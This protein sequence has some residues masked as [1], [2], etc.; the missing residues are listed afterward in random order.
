MYTIKQAA[1]LTGVAEATLR[2]WERR[3]DVVRPIRNEA[4]HRIYDKGAIAAI[5]ALRKLI[6][7][8]WAPAQAARAIRDGEIEPTFAAGSDLLAPPAPDDPP[9]V[10]TESFRDFLRAAA[11]LD[12]VGVEDSLSR[13]FGL[14]PFEFVVE[15][16]LFPALVALGDGWA[17][18]QLDVAGEHLASHA[19]RRRLASAFEAAG[20][21][22]RG[23]SVLVGLPPGCH[24]ELGAL[25]FAV[26]AKRRGLDVHFVGADLPARC[27]VAAVETRPV[28]A[29]VLAVP[30][31]EDR[32]AA[33]ATVQALRSCRPELLVAIGGRH[34]KDLTTGVLVLPHQVSTA[35]D[36]LEEL[37]HR[38]TAGR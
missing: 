29:V 25:A 8:G 38:R 26:A 35:A 31:I 11:R 9:H 20:W 19:V 1:R 16:W 28:D 22:S 34:A 18:G 37:L 23:R 15:R 3:Y 33:R 32:P 5:I 27:W 30:M 13:G 12:S 6:D 24:H 36:E 21:R 17:C 7:A 10:A 14:G 2:G 4:G